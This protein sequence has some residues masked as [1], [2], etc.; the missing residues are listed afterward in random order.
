MRVNEYFSFSLTGFFVRVLFLCS[1]F[2]GQ[3]YAQ[4]E[5]ASK[6]EGR[7]YRIAR[8]IQVGA[9]AGTMRLIGDLPADIN[10]SLSQ[11]VGGCFFMNYGLTP[12]FTA[13]LA[14]V[15]GPMYGLI[16][17]DAQS[18]AFANLNVKTPVIAPQFR[19]GYNFAGLYRNGLPGVVQPWFFVG[20]GWLFFQPMADLTDATGRPYHYWGDGSIRD[21]PEAPEN[22]GTA[23]HIDRDFIYETDLRSADLDGTGGFP[24]ST[25][26]IPMGAGVDL[27]IGQNL[28]L[29]V[30][31]AFYYTFTD[32]LD[33]IT[34]MSGQ[35]EPTR[36]IGNSLNDAFMV[37]HVGL[38]FKYYK[39]E[40]AVPV[41]IRVLPAPQLPEDFFPFDLNNDGVIQRSEVLAAINDFLNG[42]SLYSPELIGLLVDFY[43]I[44][45]PEKERIRYDH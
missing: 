17:S 45:Q 3:L 11:R 28:T 10:P 13:G 37:V 41:S 5:V 9:S 43:N 8:Y 15:S 26:T 44:Q 1:F 35:S 16:R 34:A 23:L 7:Q 2:P 20:G 31:A 12:S 30:G 22:M 18:E 40:R 42:D 19:L 24:K 27:N 14:L 32:Q 21:L 4:D 6:E 25:L 29:T 38:S 36:A 39:F 33:N